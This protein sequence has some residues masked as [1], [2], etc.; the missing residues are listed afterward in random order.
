MI[1]WSRFRIGAICLVPLLFAGCDSLEPE[2]AADDAAHHVPEHRPQSFTEG[3]RAVRSRLA[4]LSADGAAENRQQFARE[5]QELRD[6]IQWLPELAAETD[7][8]KADWNRVHAASRRLVGRWKNISASFAGNSS[9]RAVLVTSEMEGDL[10][11]L[12]RLAEKVDS[13]GQ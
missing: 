4:K 6:I 13:E 11:E 8:R 10:A 7:L 12:D 3:V 2:L 5:G 1:F 9:A